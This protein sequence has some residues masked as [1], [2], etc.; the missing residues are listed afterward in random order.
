MKCKFCEK[1][2][3]KRNNK[4]QG[5]IKETYFDIYECEECDLQVVDTENEYK[6]QYK[7][8]YEKIYKNSNILPGYSRYYKYSK[9][10]LKTNNPIKYMTKVE[11]VY[12]SVY[13]CILEYKKTIINP[14]ILEIGSG[15]GYFTYALK[16]SGLDIKGL[17]ISNEAVEKAKK[18]Y[19]DY[20][21]VADLFKYSEHNIESYDIVIMTE[22]IEHLDNPIIFLNAIKKVLKKGGILIITTPNKDAFPNDFLWHTDLPPIHLWWFSKKSLKKLSEKVGFEKI[23]FYDTLKCENSFNVQYYR[24]EKIPKQ[25]YMFE[26]D[27]SINKKLNIGKSNNLKCILKNKLK[28][29]SLI[30]KMYEKYCCFLTKKELVTKQ[31]TNII[32]AVLEK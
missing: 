27:G 2:M 9:G 29:I 28:K 14:K 8:I 31:E 22:V 30:K 5:Y 26:K 23:S 25:I 3:K 18:M 10:V 19:G 6:N 11:N 21:I 15:L 20:Y 13:N 7:D 12:N 32:C 17:D 1:E 4:I 16:K 24:D